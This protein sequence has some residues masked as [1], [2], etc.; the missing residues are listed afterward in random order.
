[1]AD[2]ALVYSSSV[3]RSPR[4]TRS[5]GRRRAAVM[6]D[7]GTYAAARIAPRPFTAVPPTAHRQARSSVNTRATPSD[8]LEWH[9]GLRVTATDALAV[10]L[11]IERS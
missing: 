1:M 4:P 11:L 9:V 6:C 2:S 3:T 7:G 8:R 5:R 10:M